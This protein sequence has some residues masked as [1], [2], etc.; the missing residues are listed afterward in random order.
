MHIDSSGDSANYSMVVSV[1]TSLIHTKCQACHSSLLSSG[2]EAKVVFDGSSKNAF[3]QP[4]PF[5]AWRGITK[6]IHFDFA[7]G[8][9][10]KRH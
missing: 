7:V 10:G 3:T 1:S 2:K 9:F 5:A 6:I 8:L 4:F